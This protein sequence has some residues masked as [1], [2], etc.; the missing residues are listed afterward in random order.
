MQYNNTT[1]KNG[2]IQLQEHY[3]GLGSGGISGNTDK[4]REFTIYNNKALKQIWTWIFES[5]GGWLFDDT[6]QTDFPI[7][8]TTLKSGQSDYA[9]EAEASAVRNVEVKDTGG[10]WRKLL[11]ITLDEITN[12]SS[13]TEFLNDNNVPRY[14]RLHGGSI[15]LYPAPNY[16]Q[17][18]SLKVYYDRGFLEF[19]YSD[20]TKE[21][22][23]AKEFHEAVA[24]GGALEWLSIHKPDAPITGKLKNEWDI[25]PVNSYRIRIKSFYAQRFRE[26]F[27]PQLRVNDSV[28][29]FK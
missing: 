9:L 22:G 4:L 27:P 12:I 7:V 11:P 13:E 19:S 29:E 25:D 15:I 17:S 26:L 3:T 1:D 5:Y 10:N 14:Y 24:V 8:T 2:I 28:S 21:P 20:T 23:F 16:T 6:N 18:A